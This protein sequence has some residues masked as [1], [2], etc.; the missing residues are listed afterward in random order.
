MD[1]KYII[2]EGLIDQQA[3]TKLVDAIKSLTNSGATK[4]TILFSSLGGSIYEGFLIATLIQNSRIPIKIHA[5]NH[6]DSIANVIFLSAKEK[7]AESHAKFYLHGAAIQGNF[8][9]KALLEKLS[10][11]RAQNTRI[12]N[13]VSENS[14]IIFKKVQEMM[15]AG[16]TLSTQEAHK[17]QMV[18]RIEHLEI[19]AFAERIEIIYVN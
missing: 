8:D 16:T 6:I 14:S 11:I 13:F 1:E 19:P 3:S 17:K 7:T 9:E 4:I 18:D 2:F 12:A 15:K 5:T 10:E